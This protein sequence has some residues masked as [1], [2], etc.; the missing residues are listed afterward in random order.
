VE[1]ERI[2][3]GGARISVAWQVESSRLHGA[4]VIGSFRDGSAAVTT[5]AHGKGTGVLVSSYP[6][7]AY[8]SH[9]DADTAASI[10][11]LLGDNIGISA[12]H[13]ESPGPGLVTRRATSADGRELVFAINW[14]TEA[15]VLV[16]L[17]GADVLASTS[18]VAAI[19]DPVPAKS[20][21][22]LVVA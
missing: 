16:G 1:D 8:N 7:L 6:S 15:A 13:W 11:A 9:A 21:V 5:N 18:L 4:E 10:V 19:G 12:T 20:A 14:T 2:D 17:D 22:L 3:L